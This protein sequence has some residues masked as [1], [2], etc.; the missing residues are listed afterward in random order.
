VKITFN[1]DDTV[2][3]D[4]WPSDDLERLLAVAKLFRQSKPVKKPPRFEQPVGTL[5]FSARPGAVFN[6]TQHLNSLQ[7]ETWSFLVDNDCQNGIHVNAVA[8]HLGI[9]DSAASTRLRRLVSM[10]YAVRLSTGYYRP[11]D[12]PSLPQQKGAEYVCQD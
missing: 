9:S 1:T 8:R 5:D 4:V 6:N 2:S 12:E 10:G 11:L 3:I 7:Y